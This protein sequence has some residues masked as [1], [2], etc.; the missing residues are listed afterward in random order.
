MATIILR[1]NR[2][3]LSFVITVLLGLSSAAMAQTI[4]NGKEVKS[5][6]GHIVSHNERTGEIVVK[7]DDS[8]GHWKL[9]HRTVVLSGKERLNLT[10]IWG[11]TKTVQVFVSKDGEVQRIS[12]L[13]WK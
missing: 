12:V 11:K 6:T 8:T 3:V 13:E 5:Y 10:E 1:A 2:I 7:T 4:M 9:S